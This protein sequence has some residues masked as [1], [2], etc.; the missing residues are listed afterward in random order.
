MILQR[1]YALALRENLLEDPAFEVLP[2]P[3]LVT[4]GEGGEY[5]GFSA[6]RGEVLIPS[7]KKVGEPKRTLDK[8]RQLKVPRPHGS[9][10]NQGFA[11]FFVDTL[12]RVL[13]LIVE[14][15]NQEKSDASRKTFWQQI[16]QVASEMHEPAIKALR[17]FGQRLHEHTERIRAD[18]A[19]EDP[20]MMDRVTFAYHGSGGPTILDLEPVRQWYSA[21]YAKFHAEKQEDGPIGVCQITGKIG[22]IPK[23]HDTKLQ[24]VPGGMSVGVSLISFDKPAFGHYGLDKAENAGIGYHGAEGYLRALTALLKNSLPSVA[25]KSGKSRLVIGGTV[26]LYWTKDPAESAFISQL[27]EPSEEGLKTLPKP[28]IRGSGCHR[29]V[30]PLSGIVGQLGPGDRAGVSGNDAARSEGQRGGLVRGSAHRG[31]LQGLLWHAE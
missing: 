1:L 10:N 14:E 19:K 6:I 22:P 27:E 3:Y 24:G 13:P 25:A 4:I 29:G 23:A 21:F 7:K 17:A 30:V 12:A 26:F 2:V 31:H 11:R 5:L 28:R 20:A 9:P 18:V 8:G 15:K 16:E